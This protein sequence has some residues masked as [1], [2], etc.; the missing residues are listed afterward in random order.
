MQKIKNFFYT[1]FPYLTKIYQAIFKRE[2]FYTFKGWGMITTGNQPPWFFKC[3][4]DLNQN[5]NFL[6]IHKKFLDQLDKK[7]FILSQYSDLNTQQLIKRVNELMWRHYILHWT[8]LFA[9]NYTRSTI[10]NFIECGV[11]DGMSIY[12]SL[13]A[14]KG[15]K[16]KKFYLYDSWSGMNKKQLLKDE[17]KNINKYNY[18]NLN[19][20]KNNLRNFKNFIVF[21]K[22]IIDR[23]FNKFT[24]PKKV[25]WVSIDLNSASPTLHCLNFFYKRIEKNGIIIFDDYGSPGYI[26]TRKAV[27]NFFK[28]K[29]ENIL[30]LPTGQAIVVKI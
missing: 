20:T 18:L 29:K 23:N 10:K 30:Q 8:T 4:N 9:Q 27:D 1:N 25:S 14:L 7:K 6:K 16:N 28:Y 3:V 19:Q 15:E 11:A 5:Q 21:N 24:N 26:L 22:G 12:Y 2:D 17:Y 13:S